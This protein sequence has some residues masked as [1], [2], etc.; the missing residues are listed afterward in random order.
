MVCRISSD[1]VRKQLLHESK[2]T[3]K[4]A[5]E[6]CK[7]NDL[8]DI[9]NKELETEEVHAIRKSSPV[10]QGTP[11]LY[12]KEKPRIQDCRICGGDHEP[13]LVMCP[14]YGEKCDNCGKMNHFASM[15]KSTTYAQNSR[16]R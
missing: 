14:A 6:I 10:K 9:C 2:L 16:Y 1:P 12:S 11:H 4:H 3:L 8:S 13:R 5:V 15:C 7:L